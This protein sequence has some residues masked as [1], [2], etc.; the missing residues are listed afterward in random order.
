[1]I[2]SIPKLLD[3]GGALDTLPALPL[4]SDR[5]NAREQARALKTGSYDVSPLAPTLAPTTAQPGQ[6]GGIPD[7][8]G[9]QAVLRIET[10]RMGG[11]GL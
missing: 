7:K 3:I 5:G 8:T 1:L 4:N 6:S 10:A 2:H 11:N 9:S